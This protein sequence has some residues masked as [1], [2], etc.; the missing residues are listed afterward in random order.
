MRDLRRRGGQA[1]GE[2][3]AGARSVAA[4]REATAVGLDEGAADGEADAA[5]A[6]RPAASGVGAVEALEDVAEV[7]RRDALA[8]VPHLDLDPSAARGS[9]GEPDV[10]SGRSVPQ[11]I[12]KEV[13]E[14]L[15][16][17]LI[18]D[19]LYLVEHTTD[20]GEPVWVAEFHESELE[21]VERP[22]SLE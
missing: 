16:H 12:L 15:R 14:H 1:D 3:G 5:A 4:G 9:D 7:L 20:D 22:A 11:R 2:G 10:P 13:S 21:L 18:G 17:P 19:G 8:R 6:R